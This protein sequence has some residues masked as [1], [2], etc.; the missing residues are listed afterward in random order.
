MPKFDYYYFLNQS[1]INLSIDKNEERANKIF[2]I[3]NYLQ[4]KVSTFKNINLKMYFISK[5]I[6]N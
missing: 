5:I 3:L 4:C 6:D 1:L 2:Y